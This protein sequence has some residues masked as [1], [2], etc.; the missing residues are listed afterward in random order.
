MRVSLAALAACPAGNTEDSFGNCIN[1]QGIVTGQ[2]PSFVPT[3]TDA[4]ISTTGPTGDT[5]A[6]PGAPDVMSALNIISAQ[7]NALAPTTQPTA[8]AGNT[9]LYVGL[10]GIAALVLFS[11]M[12]R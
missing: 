7:L 10:A 6:S 2:D 1:A 11:M 12:R 9:L 3:G 8:P 4:V 5:I